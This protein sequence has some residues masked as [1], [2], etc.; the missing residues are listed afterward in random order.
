MTFLALNQHGGMEELTLNGKAL[1]LAS[2]S[3]E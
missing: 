2:A 3:K 1:Y